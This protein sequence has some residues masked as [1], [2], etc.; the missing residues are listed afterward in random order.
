MLSDFL[1]TKQPLG[2]FRHEKILKRSGEADRSLLIYRVKTFDQITKRDAAVV[3]GRR[4]SGKTAIVS[5]YLTLS[6]D[7]QYHFRDDAD[8]DVDGVESRNGDISTWK[9]I[10]VFINSWNHL[11]EIVDKVGAD[12]RHSLHGS[13]D[14][15]SLLPETVARHW[16]RRL[17]HVVIRHMYEL[18]ISN[19]EVRRA[20]PL[21]RKYIN[22][23]D[24][25]PAAGALSDENLNRS[26]QAV[27]EQISQF[28]KQNNLSCLIVIDSLEQ[29]PVISPKF[30]KLI[31][32]FLKCVND[33]NDDEGQARILCCIPEEIEHVFSGRASNKLKDLSEAGEV[34]R[35]RWRPFDLLKVVAERY[36]A[37]LRIHLTDNVEFLRSIDHLAFA[38]RDDLKKFYDSVLPESITN[39][40]GMVEATLPYIVRHTQLLPRE[41]ILIFNRA[42]IRSH[43]MK[44]SWRFIEERAIVEA[45]E[46][47]EPDLA[48]QILK[49][50]E[51]IYPD[52][53]QACRTVIPELSP[54]FSSSDVDK[55]KAKMKNMAG[56]ECDD[57]WSMAF[58]IG[59][60][61]Y[62]DPTESRHHALYEY[63]N[64][65]YNSKAP[66]MF[67]S[68]REF[69]VHPIFSGTWKLKRPSGQSKCVYPAKIDEALWE[70]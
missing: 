62:I 33:F 60:I 17:W 31:A 38:K 32:G 12:A 48:D 51:P 64:F 58:Q 14:W 27:K 52:L 5:A 57:P 43:E 9:T 6:E 55:W 61:G 18:C 2:P 8:P 35:L 23:E 25:L 3:I 15:S 11:D 69:C 16:A 41:L 44:G 46:D 36:R 34:A 37:F 40:L 70:E 67:A 10:R 50:Y 66:I 42:I 63:G 26:F 45:V 47:Q 65:H 21:V 39:R 28:L 19:D 1:T 56:H 22:G 13:E 24:V 54:I 68:G 49:P 59:I 4:G 7:G 53:L 29:Y 20:L 30:Q